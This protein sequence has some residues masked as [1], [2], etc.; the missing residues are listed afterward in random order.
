[1]LLSP[2]EQ[3]QEPQV[4]VKSVTP[5][6]HDSCAVTLICTVSGAKDGV[7]YSWTQKDTHFN[8]SDGSHILRVS[9]SACDPDL[10]YTCT[11][12]NPVSQKS[13]QPVRIWQFC[14]G[15]RFH[16]DLSGNTRNILST[17]GA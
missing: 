1:M 3:L 12:R 2:S 7:Q 17:R 16:S 8:T 14:T 11:A 4:T 10:P 5:S 13:S 6:E 9:Q 15:K